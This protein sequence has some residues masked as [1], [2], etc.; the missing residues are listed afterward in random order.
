M[1][2]HD[3]LIES[4]QARVAEMETDQ[5]DN[6]GLLSDA[7]RAICLTRDYVGDDLLPPIE[8]WEWFDT[9]QKIAKKIPIDEWA[10]QFKI[11]VQRGIENLPARYTEQEPGE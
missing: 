10:A 8:G 3:E 9:G 5:I 11:R 2:K 1:N 6:Y 4:L 7:L